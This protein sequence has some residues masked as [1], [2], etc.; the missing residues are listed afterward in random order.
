MREI[1]T[2][3]KR[4]PYQSFATFFTL[5]LTLFLSLAVFFILTFLYGML[6][7]VESR[8]QVTVY[9]QTQTSENNIFKLK[10][11]LLSSEKVLSAKYVSKTEA[12]E[13]YKKLNKDNPL[14][15]EMVTSD[16]LPASLEI[17]AKKPSFLPEI[18]DFLKKQSGIDE[19]NFQKNI[20]DKLLSLTSIVRKT[21]IAFFAYFIITTIIILISIT[22][23][24]IAL[25]KDEIELLQL[26]GA[27]RFYIKKP[28]LKE[29][30][31]FGLLSSMVVFLIFSALF[32]VVRPYL[33]SYLSGVSNLSID[34]GFYNLVIWPLTLEFTA[35]SFLITTLFGVFI[36]IASTLLAT[37]KYIK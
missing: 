2:A 6:G 3:I 27:D 36:S 24:K 5:F 26:L 11:Q 10:E 22:H 21:S 14:L 25:K 35:A 29:A 13:I 32:F 30:L 18:A 15:L 12:Y 4:T 16:I 1:F 34:F 37:Q 7:Y 17:F 23:F 28:F 33:Q 19:V 8:P 20:I 31:F 9:F